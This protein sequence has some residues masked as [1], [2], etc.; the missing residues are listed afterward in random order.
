MIMKIENNRFYILEAGEEKWVYNTEKN[1]IEALKE[2][3]LRSNNLNSDNIRIIEVNLA[4]QKWKIQEVPWS[5]IALELIR[6]KK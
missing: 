2:E 1:A 4:E 3:V 5:K 6:G